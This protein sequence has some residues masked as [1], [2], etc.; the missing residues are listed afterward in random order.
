MSRPV[1]LVTGASSGLG[2]AL[3]I[4][5]AKQGYAIGV[6]ARREDLLREVADELTASGHTVAASAADVT[7]REA[8]GVAVASIEATLGP[9]ELAIANAGIGRYDRI[10]PF[11][12]E[13]VEQTFRVNVMG[14]V[15]TIGAVLPGMLARG[16]GHIV[17]ISSLGADRGMPGS[18]AYGA[19]KAALST[20]LD[21]LR[22]SLK[23]RG[24]AVT[25]VCPGFIRTEM[26]A[27]NKFAMPG[28][29]EAEEAARR[30][31]RRLKKRPVVYRF[32]L[33][34][35]L[36]MRT[37]R[38]LPDWAVAR[39]VPVNSSTKTEKRSH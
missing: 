29:L 17:G 12:A 35:S 33:G 16:S 18:A 14:V 7:D 21:G 13:V 39:L 2:R 30:I 5:L 32:P 27:Q 8:L 22:I 1:A 15:N 31:V 10:D 36:L 34:M 37:L 24:I 6:I 4:E 3:A 28:V 23:P 20:Y 25:T 38:H 19:S 26:T 11:D 9:I